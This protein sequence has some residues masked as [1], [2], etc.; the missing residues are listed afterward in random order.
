MLDLE[1]VLELFRSF[2]FASTTSHPYIYKKGDT[3][4]VCYTFYDNLYGELERV[5]FFDSKESMEDF[6]KRY[7][8]FKENGLKY[9]VK[10]ALDN[11]ELVNPKVL[12]LRNDKLMVR[13][14]MFNIEEF[15]MIENQKSSMDLNARLILESGNLLL[16]YDELKN[17]QIEYLKDLASFKNILRHKYFDLQKEIDLYNNY[18]ITR[19]VEELPEVL[20]M[21]GIDENTEKVL[22]DRYNQYRL[23]PPEVDVAATFVNDVWNL[24]QSLESNVTYYQ[25]QIEENDLRNEIRT[26]NKKLDYVMGLNDKMGGFF[27]KDLGKEFAKIDKFIENSTVSLSKT[28]VQEK[29]HDIEMK[30]S[31][32]EDLSIYHL[33]DYLKESMINT[34]YD[35]IAK[36]Y[37][38]DSKDDL[39][40]NKAPMNEVAA[41]L[42]KQYREKLTVE[43][44]AIMI[45]YNSKY[46][47]YFDRFM[48]MKDIDMLP[49]NKVIKKLNSTKGF[50]KI[51]SE[52]FD[53]VK[54]RIQDPANANIKE[55]LFSNVDFTDYNSFVTS[56]INMYK[57]LRSME[58]KLLLNSDIILYY[59]SS[60]YYHIF[61][62]QL[63]LVT[64]NLD[65]IINNMNVKKDV[66]GI[67]ELKKGTPLLYSPYYLDFGDLY[68]NDTNPDLTMNIKEMVYFD[69]LVNLTNVNIVKE[70][71]SVKVARYYSDPIPEED[72]NIVDEV[73]M[74]DNI[75]FDKLT[76]SNKNTTQVVEN[77]KK[78]ENVNG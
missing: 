10:I 44:Q 54:V 51:K 65:G 48:E 50:S 67:V 1:T 63:R 64:N 7:H 56:L 60:I 34:N 8:W 53:A 70:T 38:K 45:L 32:L 30:Y 58:Y 19:E 76:F 33:A 46:R 74:K 55:Q 41:D 22:K 77:N 47:E 35:D 49:L 17:R 6:L 11:Y 2:G 72:I 31:H 29:T 66:V 42:F 16:I 18:L 57:K 12:F 71:N 21:I 40:L 36:K 59:G 20:N 52:C 4:G 73:I 27:K 15:D 61:D 25:N 9:N 23:N 26:V 39:D 62:E 75:T 37:P 78:E 43:E 3:L 5:K 68:G 13:G 24:V 28:Y 69:L 14:E